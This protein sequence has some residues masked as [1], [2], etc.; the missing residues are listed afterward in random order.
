MIRQG[1]SKVGE[2]PSH[3]ATRAYCTLEINLNFS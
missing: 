3:N 2:I 1:M